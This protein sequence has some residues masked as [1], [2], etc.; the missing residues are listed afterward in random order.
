MND[1]KLYDIK[2][3]VRGK[4][5]A[6]AVDQVTADHAYEVAESMGAAWNR[7][8]PELMRDRQAWAARLEKEG[9]F[10][11]DDDSMTVRVECSPSELS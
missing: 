6:I 11:A 9:S 4:S 5:N 8:L 10:S 2:V 1:A 7:S 3:L